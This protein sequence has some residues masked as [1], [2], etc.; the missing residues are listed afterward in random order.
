M[1][2]PREE[3]IRELEA[4]LAATKRQLDAETRRA[5]EAEARLASLDAGTEQMSRN[6]SAAVVRPELYGAF[7]AAQRR[8]DAEKHRADEAEARANKECERADESA[9]QLE[10]QMQMEVCLCVRN[11]LPANI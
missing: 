5:D 6:A 1:G 3:K 10:E 2:D 7:E 11:G 4:A 8:A 9:E